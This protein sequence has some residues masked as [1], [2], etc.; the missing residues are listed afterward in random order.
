MQKTYLL[1][2][3]MFQ[4]AL[5]TAQVMETTDKSN[6]A[7][8]GPQPA[9]VSSSPR[10]IRRETPVMKN[11]VEQKQSTAACA[12]HEPMESSTSMTALR[13]RGYGV[14]NFL[15]SYRSTLHATTNHTLKFTALAA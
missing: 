11:S 15:P 2:D 9:L 10:V 1:K 14:S 3:L 13:L 4:E 5:H 7:L 6:K 8:Q 12:L